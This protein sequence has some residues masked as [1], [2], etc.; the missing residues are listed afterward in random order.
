MRLKEHLSANHRESPA[1]R[2][3]FE[4]TAVWDPVKKGEPD[5]CGFSLQQA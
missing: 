1:K 4:M 2:L 5:V 3:S